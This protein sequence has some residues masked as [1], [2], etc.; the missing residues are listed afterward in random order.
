MRAKICPNFLKKAE[1]LKTA[2]LNPISGSKSLLLIKNKKR[3]GVRGGSPGEI[4][5]LF[6]LLLLGLVAVLLLW[7]RASQLPTCLGL[8]QLPLRKHRLSQL[9]AAWQSCQG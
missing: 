3:S 5:T 2:I 4:L 1:L 6:E 9:F 7:R 8:A